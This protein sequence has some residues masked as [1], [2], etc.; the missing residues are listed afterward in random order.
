MKKL[1]LTALCILFLLVVYNI[2]LVSGPG[3]GRRVPWKAPVRR[4]A[5]GHFFKAELPGDIA[6]EHVPDIRIYETL[7]CDYPGYREYRNRICYSPGSFYPFD[8][9]YGG[10]VGYC[11]NKKSCDY[12]HF[13]WC[14][15]KDPDLFEKEHVYPDAGT[16]KKYYFGSDDFCRPGFVKLHD[17]FTLERYWIAPEARKYE[18]DTFSA[19]D[20]Y[21]GDYLEVLKDGE[22]VIWTSAQRRFLNVDKNVEGY[23]VLSDYGV[24]YISFEDG[25]VVSDFYEKE[26]VIDKFDI[27]SPVKKGVMLTDNIARIETKEG[28]VVHWRIR[29]SKRDCDKNYRSRVNG[30]RLSPKV[31]GSIIWHNDKYKANP[32]QLSWDFAPDA[33]KEPEYK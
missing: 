17:K 6:P 12:D 30:D 19:I 8:P 32:W 10:W 20:F 11:S 15:L 28:G 25:D 2:R 9:R 5:V 21:F 16:M 31:S 14:Y 1:L 22:K 13:A 4:D 26:F 18:N 27:Y 3:L 24:D 29:L 23:I 33:S 7:V